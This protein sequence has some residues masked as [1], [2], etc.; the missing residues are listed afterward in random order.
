MKS[1]DFELK[2]YD[3]YIE[4][5]TNF[6]FENIDFFLMYDRNSEKNNMIYK[7]MIESLAENGGEGTETDREITRKIYEKLNKHVEDMILEDEGQFD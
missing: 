1:W 7:F 4:D 2:I 3:S 5:T 6:K